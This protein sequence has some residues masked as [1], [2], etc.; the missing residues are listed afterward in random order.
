MSST[1]W[2]MDFSL[3]PTWLWLL[4]S[5]QSMSRREQYW[6]PNM[7]PVWLYWTASI[8]EGAALCS[9]WNRHFGHGF[10]FPECNTSTKLSSLCIQNALYTIIL[11]HIAFLLIKELLLQQIKCN[12][13]RMLMIIH[14]SYHGPCASLLCLISA[15][16]WLASLKHCKKSTYQIGTQNTP[17]IFLNWVNRCYILFQKFLITL[18]KAIFTYPT[19]RTN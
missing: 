4:L 16:C 5:A 2:N 8:V 1:T 6:A 13:W 12:N 18:K 7:A 10:D 19:T 9:Y 17:T 14:W 15:F 11:F 3:R